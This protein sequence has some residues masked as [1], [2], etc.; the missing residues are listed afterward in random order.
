MQQVLPATSNFRN[1]WLH[2]AGLNGCCYI[3]SHP[4]VLVPP[5]GKALP[6]RFLGCVQI[7]IECGWHN[8]MKQRRLPISKRVWRAFKDYPHLNHSGT[9][10]A[11]TG[12]TG[13]TQLPSLCPASRAW[14]PDARYTTLPL[15]SSLCDL[16]LGTG[17]PAGNQPPPSHII[18]FPNPPKKSGGDPGHIIRFFSFRK[19]Q[20]V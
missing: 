20:E 14:L 2:D 1:Q 4:L 15:P 12:H 3:G 18:K 13:Q 19:T 11:N 7:P 6:P 17:G 8:A 9:L 16:E 10:L 5:S